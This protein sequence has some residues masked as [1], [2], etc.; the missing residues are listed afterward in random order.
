M[1]IEVA[2]K[3]DNFIN[4]LDSNPKI[5]NLKKLEK[6]IDQDVNIKKLA[7]NFNAQKNSY[8]KTNFVSDSFIAAKKELYDNPFVKEYRTLMEELQFVILYL[9]QQLAKI[10]NTKQC[11]K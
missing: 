3:V 4:R 11:E 9:N 8:E 6:K 1:P 7:D 5:V 10:I 2:N